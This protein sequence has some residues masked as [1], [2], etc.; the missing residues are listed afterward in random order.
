MTTAERWPDRLADLAAQLPA[1]L[2]ALIDAMI[3]IV[4]GRPGQASAAL[5]RVAEYGVSTQVVDDLVEATVLAFGVSR[6]SIAGRTALSEVHV[7]P[8]DEAD[9]RP[10]DERLSQHFAATQDTVPEAIG[11]LVK[12]LPA[13]GELYLDTRQSLFADATG[14]PALRELFLA[15]VS[16]R[17]GFVP[18]GQR[19]LARARSLGMPVETLRTA[20]TAVVLVEGTAGWEAYGRALWE[21]PDD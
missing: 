9:T 11:D 13:L 5:A 14:D 3:A 6:W 20:L 18:G 17:A 7:T 4:A 16:A 12:R 8:A 21:T 1:P 15:L 10:L 2:D 19:H